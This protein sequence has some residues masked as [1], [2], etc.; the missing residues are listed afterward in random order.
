MQFIS[1][2]FSDLLHSMSVE[3]TCSSYTSENFNN[4]QLAHHKLNG[5]TVLYSIIVLKLLRYLHS[6]G[7]V[8]TWV[9]VTGSKLD[10]C[11]Y[12]PAV[13]VAIAQCSFMVGQ[14]QVDMVEDVGCTIFLQFIL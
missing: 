12:N 10:L 8:S 6:I 13:S 3:N 9:G 14:D 2:I 1:T 4:F 5:E 11:P 7:V